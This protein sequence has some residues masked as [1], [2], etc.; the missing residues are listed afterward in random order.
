MSA[1]GTSSNP[2][3]VA[4][5]GSGP[6]GFYTVSNLLKQQGLGVEMDMFEKLPTPF[7]LVRA[8]VAPDHQKDKSVTR[9]YEK[10]AVDGAFRFF[11]NVEFGRHLTLDDVHRHYHQV[12]FATGA[13][14][15]RALGIPGEDAIGSHPATDFVAWYNGHPEYARHQFDLSAE[16]VAI[17]GL[18]NVA[19][20]V[21]RILCKSI[22]ELKTTDIADHALT[23]LKQS[24]VKMVYILGRRGPAQAAFTPAEIREIG[25]LS[26]TDVRV[27]PE[28]A[29][30]DPL[31]RTALEASGDRNATR[32]TEIIQNIAQWQA[33][34]REKQL[35][36]RF[37]VSP[38]EILTDETNRVTGIRIVKNESVLGP[39]GTVRSRATGA[40]ETLPVQLVF[41]SVG[42]RGVRLSG[43][44]YDESSGVI[45]NINGRVTG[46]DGTPLPGYYAVGWIKRGP[47]GVIG[48]NKTDAKETVNCMVEDALAGRC[49]NPVAASADAITKLIEAR[50]PQL[51]TFEN[52]RKLDEIEISK[53]LKAD[54]PRVKFTDVS[55]MLRVLER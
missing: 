28:E 21:A 6:A 40:I 33:A 38:T 31:S 52:W 46:E 7:G 16:A 42:Y 32:N 19:I 4:I 45:P 23:A 27:R 43:V 22:D 8:G 18:G 11:G 50:Q 30:L 49:L 13:Q 1:I 51:V 53:G 36:I 29:V 20:D 39:D 15:D 26:G 34:G 5:I 54:R 14:S 12:V 47:S 9:T 55:E 44:P 17:I 25:D 37:M 3:R 48:S 24:R 10:S 41:R 2:L 35:I